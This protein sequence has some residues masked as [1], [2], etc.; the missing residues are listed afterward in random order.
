MGELL[1]VRHGESEGNSRG[2][3]QGCA[4]FPLTGLG[5]RQAA[6]LGRVL[7]AQSIDEFYASDLQRA[8]ETAVIAA[9][10]RPIVA[11]PELRELDVG[12]WQARAKA[13]II[14][15]AVEGP[16]YRQ[17]QLHPGRFTLPA[18]ES[19]QQLQDR[20]RRAIDAIVQ[21]HRGSVV[22]VVSHGMFIRSWLC[23]VLGWDLDRLW[24]LRIPNTSVSRV[25]W[26]PTP[27]VTS[28]GN[29]DHLADQGDGE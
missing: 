18:G 19:I 9:G 15:D 3:F 14:E 4:D 27:V 11:R 25:L 28:I 20:A 17:Y 5:R 7:A 23:H 8:R 24:E 26:N 29:I 22:V 1:L 2:I 13:E 12:R 16:L 6:A 10:N 21:H